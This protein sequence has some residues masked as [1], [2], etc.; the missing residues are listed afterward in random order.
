MLCGGKPSLRPSSTS[1]KMVTIV[2]TMYA[3][4][5]ATKRAVSSSMSVPCSIERTPNSTQRRTAVAD[6]ACERE[7]AAP[8]VAQRRETAVERV[9]EHAHRVRGAVRAALLL[10]ALHVHVARVRVHVRVD[11]AGHQ[12]PPADVEDPRLARLDGLGGDLA[13]R[14]ALDEDAHARGA[15]GAMPVEDTGI[16]EEQGGGHQVTAFLA[17]NCAWSPAPVP[18]GSAS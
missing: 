18:S 12:R 1:A 8:H 9:A 10:D 14:A 6:R 5:D 16:L 13:N 3:P 7:V 15:I 2:G 11:H 17:R 4:F